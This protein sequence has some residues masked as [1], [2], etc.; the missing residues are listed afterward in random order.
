MRKDFRMESAGSP[1]YKKVALVA[2][3]PR[4]NA[5]ALFSQVDL[6]RILEARRLLRRWFRLSG[7]PLLT[8]P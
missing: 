5:E 3:Y 6:R 8:L 2:K 7:R 1:G 4:A